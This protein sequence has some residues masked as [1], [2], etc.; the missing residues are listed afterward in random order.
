M[1]FPSSS[2]GNTWQSS[3]QTGQLPSPSSGARL[4]PQTPL[5]GRDGSLSKLHLFGFASAQGM[6]PL[7]ASLG[8]LA[9]FASEFIFRNFA[10][11][12][13]SIPLDWLKRMNPLRLEGLKE[14]QVTDDYAH[15]LLNSYCVPGTVHAFLKFSLNF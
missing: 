3:S 15:Y 9:L 11:K 12:Q 10:Q 8:A 1:N 14:V 4:Q 5:G 7:G 13:A 2:G 6:E